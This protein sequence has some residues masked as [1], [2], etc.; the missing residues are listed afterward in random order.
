MDN[1]DHAGV[2]GF[3][4]CHL[5]IAGGLVVDGSGNAAF[6]ADVA[7]DG[8]RIAALGRLPE[9]QADERIDARR[10]PAFARLA[11][12]GGGKQPVR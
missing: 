7:I 6:E 11:E 3:G 10:Y 8:D 9:W 12:F 5:L 1:S 2:S 4:R